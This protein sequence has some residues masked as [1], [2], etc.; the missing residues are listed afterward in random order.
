[1]SGENERLAEIHLI[2]KERESMVRVGQEILA[3]L[4]NYPYKTPKP[5]RI[6]VQKKLMEFTSH[7]TNISGFC[8]SHW[9]RAIFNLSYHLDMSMVGL[10]L[11]ASDAPFLVGILNMAVGIQVDFTKRPFR[12]VGFDV[13]ALNARL[14][15]F[16]KR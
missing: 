8:D 3:L 10:T 6:E 9:R 2:M 16:V 11:H 4:G 14:K 15:A 12:L 13:R 7:L 1:M 5:D